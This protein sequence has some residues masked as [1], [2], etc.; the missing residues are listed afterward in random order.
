MILRFGGF[1][2]RGEFVGFEV[3]GDLEDFGLSTIWR[4]WWIFATIPIFRGTRA[5]MPHSGRRER[6]SSLLNLPLRQ[7]VAVWIYRA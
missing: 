6:A 2:R 7:C 5:G 4:S 1:G 3:L